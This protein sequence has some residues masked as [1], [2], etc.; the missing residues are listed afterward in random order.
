MTRR[1]QR[2]V[3]SGT[4]VSDNVPFRERCAGEEPPAARFHAQ[5][6]PF[7]PA[8]HAQCADSSTLSNSGTLDS[9]KVQS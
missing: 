1:Y 5:Q 7:E 9:D 3:D 6:R 2:I 8:S 4:L